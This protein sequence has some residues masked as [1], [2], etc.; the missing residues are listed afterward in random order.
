VSPP[1]QRGRRVNAALQQVLAEAVRGLSDPRVGFVTI[2]RVEAA[3]DT[4]TAKVYFTALRPE[5]RAPSQE[6]LESARGVLQG[7]LAAELRT[8]HT[9]HLQFVYDDQAERAERLTRLI[10]EV[11]TPDPP[12]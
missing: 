9:P 1:G 6:G 5:D 12:A 8:K 2:T 11:T 7:R 10:D 3:P 4:T